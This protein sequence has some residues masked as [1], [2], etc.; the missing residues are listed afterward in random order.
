M[1]SDNQA[2][3]KFNCVST[4]L[5]NLTVLVKRATPG[6]IHA[7]YAH[8]VVGNKSLGKTVTSCALAGSLK[9]PTKVS[10]NIERNFSCGGKNINELMTEVLLRAAARDLAK[11]KTLRD[12]TARNAVLPTPLL[13]EIA[14][15]NGE[16]TTEVLLKIIAN[17][18][19]KQQA[20]NSAEKLDAKEESRSDEDNKKKRKDKINK[21]R[22]GARRYRQ[23]LSRL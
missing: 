9:A 7:T 12:W 15:T 14:L 3:S 8:A 16:T 4:D 2:G 22:N 5:Q 6:E 21:R 17:R 18:I 23:N 1:R 10:I 20:E 11:L 13:R 19:N